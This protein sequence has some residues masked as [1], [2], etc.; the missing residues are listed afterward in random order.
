MYTVFSASNY[1]GAG[2]NKGAV[3][4]FKEKA[5]RPTKHVKWDHRKIKHNA[6]TQTVQTR[7]EGKAAKL[8]AAVA[9]ASIRLSHLV[10]ASLVTARSVCV[11]FHQSARHGSPSHVS[12]FWVG[13]NSA[14]AI[15]CVERES[16][17]C[18]PSSFALCVAVG[19]GADGTHNYASCI[20]SPSRNL[21][22][23]TSLFSRL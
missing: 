9:Q 4:I 22:V 18:P 20:A 3:V 23:A 17:G 13:G 2:G 11:S 6:L 15:R 14:L 1:C 21:G 10:I 16:A 19:C 12:V 8:A 7:R 5:E